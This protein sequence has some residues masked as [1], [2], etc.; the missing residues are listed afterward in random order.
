MTTVT[1]VKSAIKYV[2]IKGSP[3]EQQTIAGA[4]AHGKGRGNTEQT[5]TQTT[6]AHAV[7][8]EPAP[9]SLEQAFEQ[10]RRAFDE[11]SGLH[12]GKCAE[13]ER[14]QARLT[15][16][17]QDLR[18]ERERGARYA[19]QIA[20]QEGELR[21]LRTGKAA[22]EE[23]NTRLSARIAKGP[24]RRNAGLDERSVLERLEASEKTWRSEADA[25]R[26]KA[27]AYADMLAHAERALGICAD[28]CAQYSEESSLGMRET[29]KTLRDFR[30][31]MPPA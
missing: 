7:Q 16:A 15:R 5:R 18:M 19:E 31:S 2:N 13:L 30:A 11:L 22:A 14:A 4:P 23:I 21:R 8:G 20:S 25:L 10:G 28:L 29:Q 27:A 24:A 17:E 12:A 26:G 1:T 6:R 3:Q 9:G